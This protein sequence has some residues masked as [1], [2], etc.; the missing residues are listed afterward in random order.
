MTSVGWLTRSLAEVP[1]GDGWLGPRERDVL[2]RLTVE[3]RRSDWRLGRF[4]AKAAVA[5]WLG[6]SIARVEIVADPDGAP[7]VRLDG[8]AAPVAVSISHRA[9]RALVA[10]GHGGTSLGCDLELIEPRSRAFVSDW[11]APAEVAL[12]ERAGARRDLVANLAWTAKEAAAKMRREGLRLDVRNAVAVPDG[13]DDPAAR[14]HPLAVA[15]ADGGGR[16]R[17]WWRTE[18]GW[19]TAI[20]GEPAPGEPRMLDSP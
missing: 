2:A 6:V 19:V 3:K 15:W 14:W 1:V 11:L 7:Q 16:S 13:L 5:R 12:V 17:G 4:A 9:E 8:D 10:V 18:P 20:I